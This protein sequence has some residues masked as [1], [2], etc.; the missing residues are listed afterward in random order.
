M[1]TGALTTSHRLMDR[2]FIENLR[3]ECR[4]GVTEEERGKPQEVI[5]DVVLTLDL[6]RS[7]STKSLEDTVDY[8]AARLQISNF[9]S[10]GEF[11]LL[12]SLAEGVASLFLGK[13]N[14]QG[15]TVRVRKKKYSD[16]PSIGVEIERVSS[17]KG[18]GTIPR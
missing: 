7:A 6:S 13:F 10:H 8:R 11:I 17:M 3:S 2:I 1:P 15:V 12:E 4:I 9:A 18:R 14:V 16:T 5:F